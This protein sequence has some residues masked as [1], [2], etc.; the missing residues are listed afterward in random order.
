MFVSLLEEI[1]DV[2]GISGETHSETSLN[3]WLSVPNQLISDGELI[4]EQIKHFIFVLFKLTK[5]HT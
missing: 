2:E 3:S 4:E 5:H 1:C